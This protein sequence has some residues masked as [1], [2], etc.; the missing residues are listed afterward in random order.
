MDLHGL[1]S[2]PSQTRRS[3]HWWS[4]S[5]AAVALRLASSCDCRC[6][7]SCMYG[8]MSRVFAYILVVWK[9]ICTH[10]IRCACADGCV[11]IVNQQNVMK[12]G[13]NFETGKEKTNW[14]AGH[15]TVGCLRACVCN[16]DLLLDYYISLNFSFL[17]DA[18]IL[19][20]LARDK[21]KHSKSQTSHSCEL[22]IL[23]KGETTCLTKRE[24][25]LTSCSLYLQKQTCW[26]R[27]QAKISNSLFVY[28]FCF[29]L[30]L[31]V[32][33]LWLRFSICRQTVWYAVW[34][35]LESNALKIVWV[36]SLPLP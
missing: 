24:E 34:I 30:F 3:C 23:H 5:C 29:L 31:I 10:F 33:K 27:L 15:V 21:Q 35:L 36:L 25:S 12:N 16:R 9:L 8:Y 20:V 11:L 13:L 17:T 7:D 28:F 2:F 1:F 26:S 6:V 4:V 22:H 18:P 14:K 32:N 19:K